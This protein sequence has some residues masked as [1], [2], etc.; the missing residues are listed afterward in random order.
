LFFEDLVQQCLANFVVDS[1]DEDEED[2]DHAEGALDDNDEEEGIWRRV[3]RSMA[4]YKYSPNNVVLAMMK[5]LLC[6]ARIAVVRGYDESEPDNA[7]H[8]I[9]FLTNPVNLQ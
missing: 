8:V 3:I 2:E 1:D 9:R 5:V 6:D 7:P 4:S